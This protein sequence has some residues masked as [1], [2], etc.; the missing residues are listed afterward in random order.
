[1]DPT[2]PVGRHWAAPLNGPVP[3]G[4]SAVTILAV[5]WGAALGAGVRMLVWRRRRDTSPTRSHDRMFT[6]K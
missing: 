6:V 5:L 1:M 3:S 2:D 4:W